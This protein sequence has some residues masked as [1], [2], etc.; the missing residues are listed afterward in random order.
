VG[1]ID[2]NAPC[3]RGCGNP[4][5]PNGARKITGWEQMRAQGGANQVQLR[6]ETGEVVCPGCLQEMK[7]GIGEGQGSFNL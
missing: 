4:I 2:P 3:S 1:S 7:L 6:E 5:G